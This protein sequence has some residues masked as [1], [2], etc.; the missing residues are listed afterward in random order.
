[1]EW[2]CK[3]WGATTQWLTIGGQK[4][5]ENMA[6]VGRKRWEQTTEPT[7]KRAPRWTK[8]L[9]AFGPP[10]G[11]FGVCFLVEFSLELRGLWVG[12]VSR[13]VVHTAKLVVGWM[14]QCWR[15]L[16]NWR[17]NRRRCLRSRHCRCRTY[18]LARSRWVYRSRR[19]KY[20]QLVRRHGCVKH[21][22]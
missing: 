1:M 11:P 8:S 21:K 6:H 2:W 16:H 14:E 4:N 9:L 15:R 18:S 3:Q 20:R 19:Q 10:G 12:L 13:L 7:K 22:E 17:R 5:E